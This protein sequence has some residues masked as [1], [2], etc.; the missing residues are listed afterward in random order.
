VYDWNMC[1][2]MIAHSVGG[3]A[4]GGPHLAARTWLILGGLNGEHASDCRI[5]DY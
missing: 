2:R 1:S 5:D 4:F 3:L